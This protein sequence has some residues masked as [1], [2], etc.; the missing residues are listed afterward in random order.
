M[1]DNAHTAISA[2]NLMKIYRRGSEEIRAVNDVT[3]AV[4]EGQF[5]SFTGP[6]GSGK[7]TLI[8]I[9]GCLDNPSSGRL[10]ILEKNILYFQKLSFLK[11]IRGLFS[12][13]LSRNFL[14][15]CFF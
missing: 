2:R 5:V 3:L 15:R 13:P 6:S 1:P 7:T 9:L 12:H 4:E 8:N 11:F 14:W 10:D